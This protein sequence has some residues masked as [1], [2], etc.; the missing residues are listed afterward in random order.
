[1]AENRVGGSLDRQ[2]AKPM[3]QQRASPCAFN[4]P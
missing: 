2:R 3:G 1:M 4:P